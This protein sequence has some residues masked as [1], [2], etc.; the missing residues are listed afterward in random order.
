M[1][2]QENMILRNISFYHCFAVS[3]RPLPWPLSS[4]GWTLCLSLEGGEFFRSRWASY[5]LVGVAGT[6][7]VVRSSLLS[8][9]WL[10]SVGQ[11]FSLIW[12]WVV[13]NNNNSTYEPTRSATNNDIR[14]VRIPRE[15]QLALTQRFNATVIVPW[16]SWFCDNIWLAIYL[17]NQTWHSW[18]YLHTKLYLY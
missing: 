7:P 9:E 14:Y 4:L 15:I 2:R 1:H 5:W 11:P 12:F 13:Y 3:F 18:L 10:P 8:D 6:L 17:W 16:F